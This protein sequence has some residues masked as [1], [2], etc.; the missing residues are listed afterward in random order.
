MIEIQVHLK[1]L[2]NVYS[3][4]IPFHVSLLYWDK[5]VEIDRRH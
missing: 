1:Y 3:R 4:K 5:R 2:E